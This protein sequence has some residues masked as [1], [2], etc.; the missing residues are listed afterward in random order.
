[1][2]L[3]TNK[4]TVRYLLE[5]ALNSK[6]LSAVDEVLSPNFVDHTN[7]PG[8]TEGPQG[9]KEIFAVFHAAFPDF[10]YT[11]EF[12]VAERDLVVVRGTYTFTHK[13]E[14]FGIAP[15]GKYVIT[16]GMHLFRLAD[17]KIMEHWCNNDDLGTMRQLGVVS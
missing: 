12:E 2:S 14:F 9:L 10:H 16:T 8:W 13:G 15:T 4:A 3:E 1:M 7:P 6:R 5:N 17:G 11:T